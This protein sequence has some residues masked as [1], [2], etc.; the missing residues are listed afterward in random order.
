[1]RALLLVVLA[2][3]GCRSAPPVEALSLLGRELR[4]PAVPDERR[5]ELEADLA[6]ARA[7]H[8]AAPDDVDAAIWHGRRLAY[9]G[10]YRDAIEVYSEALRRH[11]E[12]YRLLRHR[13]HRWITLRRF[14][15]AILD[16][17]RAAK[18]AEPFE[19]A[20][21]PDGQPNAAGV[22]TSTDKT[23]IW[24]HLGLALYLEDRKDEALHAWLE[25][26]DHA[27]N[28]DM[29][30]ATTHWLYTVLRRLGRDGEA[31][32]AL[33]PIR[34]DLRILENHGYHRLCLLYKG[35]LAPEE[36]VGDGQ[37]TSVEDATVA[38]GVASWYLC[39]G[40]RESA[41]QL[42]ARIVTGDA[43]AAFG[44]VAAEADV[45]RLGPFL[46]GR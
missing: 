18:L 2:L 6:A 31:N 28:P 23:N 26:R 44:Y 17:R 12:S 39:E 38:Y 22:P 42:L 16:L 25:C 41:A 14:N 43:W 15:A 37:Q 13:G 33:A 3:A 24:Y 40:E 36:L 34:A 7:A 21:E 11:P 5:A 19:D 46:F 9:L 32:E 20:V 1:M 27:R 4:R 30:V 35:E 8:E 10:R 29:L 45:A